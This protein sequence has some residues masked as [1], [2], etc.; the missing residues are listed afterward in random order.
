MSALLPL[1]RGARTGWQV[2][3]VYQTRRH[4]AR[5][6]TQARPGDRLQPLNKDD[7]RQMAEIIRTLNAALA[8]IEGEPA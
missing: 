5:H 1:M 2:R 7:K 4:P 8:N 6:R 3:A